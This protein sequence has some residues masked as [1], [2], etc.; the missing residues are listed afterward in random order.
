MASDDAASAPLLQ[1][2]NVE[3]H[4]QG[5]DPKHHVEKTAETL[6]PLTAGNSSDDL[7][8]SKTRKLNEVL[9]ACQ[10]QDLDALKALAI[11]DAGLIND[12][13]RRSACMIRCEAAL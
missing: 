9:T 1:A 6:P 13:A 10:G 11:S 5:L 12:H 4:A 8:D 3:E 2:N 7:D